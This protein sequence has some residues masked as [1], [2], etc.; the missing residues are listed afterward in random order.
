MNFGL[1]RIATFIISLAILAL[2]FLVL[3]KLSYNNL[4]GIRNFSESSQ[5]LLT[6]YGEVH[7]KSM[8]ISSISVFFAILLLLIPNITNIVFRKKNNEK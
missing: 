7:F 1:K 8:L 4:I 3:Y 5:G 6:L 2:M